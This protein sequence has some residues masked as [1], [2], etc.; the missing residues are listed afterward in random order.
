MKY[1]LVVIMVLLCLP[2]FG[3]AQTLYDTTVKA[4]D[5]RL[6]TYLPMLKDKRVA[7]VINQTSMVKDQSILDI[8][9]KNGVK[10]MRV[11]VPEHGFRGSADAGETIQDEYDAATKLPIVSLYGNHKKPV[12]DDL[13]DVDMV[14][15]DLQDVGVRFYTYIS[16]LELCMEACA[17]N[18]I[19]FMVLDR[20]NPNGFYVDGPVLERENKSFVGM[21]AIPIVYGLTAGEYA[22]MLV[23]E[24]WLNSAA[25]LDLTVIKCL[26]YSHSKKYE[27]PIAPSPNLKTMA[28][29]YA[30]P[31]MCLF[32]GTPVS[33][34]RG[35]AY[36]FL[37]YGCPEFEDKFN[38]TFTPRS[39]AGA[40]NPPFQDKPCF[41]ELIGTDAHDV[42]KTINNRIQLGWLK[43]A[44]EAYPDKNRFFYSFFIKLSGTPVLAAQ[45]KNG[46]SEEEIRASWRADIIKYKTIRCKYLLYDDFE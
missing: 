22:R 45:I 8:L 14:V 12:A 13:Y 32:E 11:L 17:Q 1:Y 18:K 29:I 6:E 35:T 36:P 42:L 40:Q 27:L 20:P 39:M 5:T 10:V 34:G 24:R 28:A 9:L 2:F 26:N 41:G 44:Y 37:Q 46:L 31:S 19:K 33:L 16:T 25:D 43:K 3:G 21:Q 15:Y 23:G 30:Y 4:G 7:L 38:Y